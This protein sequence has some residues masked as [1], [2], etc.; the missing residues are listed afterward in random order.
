MNDLFL[1][2][3]PVWWG[4]RCTDGD[5]PE[6]QINE[7]KPNK[8]YGMSLSRFEKKKCGDSDR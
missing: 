1:S 6:V 7:S 5:K 8:I 2:E 4:S 3:F